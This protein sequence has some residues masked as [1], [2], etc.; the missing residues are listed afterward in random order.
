MCSWEAKSEF[1]DPELNFS[2]LARKAE[3]FQEFHGGA[4]E[5]PL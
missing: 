1:A 5:M 3:V 2:F 4:I